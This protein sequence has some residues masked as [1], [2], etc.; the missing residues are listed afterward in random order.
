MVKPPD[1]NFR[2]FL[3]LENMAS[4][5]HSI[6][7]IL[8]V[9]RLILLPA[10]IALFF[11]VQPWAVWSCLALY[12][13]GA[14]TDFFDGWV[15]RAMNSVSEFGKFLDPIADKVFVATI[16]LMLVATQRIDGLWVICV[17]IILMREFLVAGLREYLAPKGIKLPVTS[18]AK[19]KTATQMLALGL[20]I[21]I[22]V[23]PGIA[24]IG[25]AL[26][27]I[28]AGLTVV[29]GWTYLKTGMRHIG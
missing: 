5:K 13:I 23:L 14:L 25:L 24:I 3:H 11:S 10:I 22:P 7:N 29:T 21:M 1:N 20:L 19:W 16:M 8:T 15:A 28:A 4:F 17:I 12:I 9:M 6:P 26:L 18:L 2:W 27:A